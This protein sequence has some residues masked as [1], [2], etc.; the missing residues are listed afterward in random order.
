M[1]YR[2]L[3]WADALN[4]LGGSLRKTTPGSEESRLMWD[5][6]APSF[7][8][9]A[10]RS[11]YI[12]KLI[13]LLTLDPRDSVLDFGCGSGTLSIPLAKR[14]FRVIA[15]DFSPVMLDQLESSCAKEGVL[16]ARADRGE[17]ILDASA[18]GIIAYERSW[19]QSWNDL[20]IADVAVSSRSLITSDIDDSIGKFEAHARKRAVVTIGVGSLHFHDPAI[21]K[22]MGRDEAKPKE[23]E[24]LIYLLNYLFSHGRLPRLEYITFAGVHQR[25]TRE[26]LMNVLIDAHEPVN[27]AERLAAEAYL[28]E[29]IAFDE[30]SGRYQLDYPRKDMWAYLDWETPGR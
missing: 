4:N 22:A 5:K 2:A 18:G 25:E 3:D 14:G 20:P 7:A 6:K 27:A 28:D 8:R 19:Q 15:C 17:I 30:K 24:E 16:F 23:P 10:K 26:E 9:K 11:D 21:Y 13:A 1:D 29:H 12:D